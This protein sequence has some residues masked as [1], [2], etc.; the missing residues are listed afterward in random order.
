MITD[1]LGRLGSSWIGSLDKGLLPSFE[2]ENPTEDVL[3]KHSRIVRWAP[4]LAMLSH[5][6]GSCLALSI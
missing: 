4:A 3:C 6:D 5:R 2:E 1:H